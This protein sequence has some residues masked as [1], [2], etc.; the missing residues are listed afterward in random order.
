MITITDNGNSSITITCNRHTTSCDYALPKG[1]IFPLNNAERIYIDLANIAFVVHLGDKRRWYNGTCQRI[2]ASISVYNVDLFSTMK[3]SIEQLLNSMT[4]DRWTIEFT[5]RRINQCRQQTFSTY[6]DIERVSLWSGGLDS[7]VGSAILDTKQ[8]EGNTLKVL[9]GNNVSVSTQA[10]VL[11]RKYNC[12]VN[13]TSY[14]IHQPTESKRKQRFRIR[15]P[16]NSYCRTRGFAF[17]ILAAIQAHQ[18]GLNKLYV[19]ENGLGAI[20]YWQD[21]I[22]TSMS[23]H[24]YSLYQLSSILSMIW[25]GSFS[26]ENPFIFKT[27][28]EMIKQSGMLPE[29][30]MMSWSCDSAKRIVGTQIKQCG[31]CSSC[32]LRRVSLHAVFGAQYN[33]EFRP[34]LASDEHKV[35]CFFDS[36]KN[37]NNLCCQPIEHG[38]GQKKQIQTCQQVWMIDNPETEYYSS[39]IEMYKQFIQECNIAMPYILENS[40][41]Q[42][43]LKDYWYSS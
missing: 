4:D 12:T 20:N 23:V 32:L 3:V 2:H 6:R 13:N 8:T 27:K 35:R 25:Q 1:L 43:S 26:I 34:L 11:H 7:L 9:S 15:S 42:Q 5:E 40:S 41:V 39:M 18:L 10:R 14:L 19:Y 36:I 38:F 28:A 30:L 21:N 31:F 37:L 24:P 22:S 33:E 17:M 29:I 16:L